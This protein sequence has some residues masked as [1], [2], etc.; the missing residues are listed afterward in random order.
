LKICCCWLYAISKYGYPP[1]LENTL[2]AV[3]EMIDLGFQAI[4]L[5]AVTSQNLRE[6]SNIRKKIREIC[7]SRGASIV[8]FCPIFRDLVNYDKRKR[9]QAIRLFE[10]AAELASYFDSETIQTDTFTPPLRFEGET[11]Y[12][13]AISF[14]KQVSVRIPPDFR[15]PKFWAILVDS[16]RRC[17]RIAEQHGLKFCVEPRVGESVSN[18]DAMLRLIE[19]VGSSN[20]GAVLDTGHLHAQKEILPLSAEKLGK[21]IFYIHVSDNDGRDNFHLRPGKGT[22]D[23]EG[24]FRMLKRIGF[25]GYYAVDIGNVPNLEDEMIKSKRFLERLGEKLNL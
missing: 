21:K 24:L 2:K 11:P 16:M 18:T 1:S 13:E 5:E 4:E 8:N 14:G 12:K 20:F 10:D 9:S 3:R 6:L 7:E 19:A 22:I 17:D 25:R 23:W 15:W